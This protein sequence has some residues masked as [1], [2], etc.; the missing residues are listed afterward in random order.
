MGERQPAIRDRHADRLVAEV[1]RGERAAG[2]QQRRQ[3][4]YGNDVSGNG[5][6]PLT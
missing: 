6:F 3:V 1:E 2:R 4:L 5:G